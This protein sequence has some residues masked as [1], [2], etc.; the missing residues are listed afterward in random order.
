MGRYWPILNIGWYRYGNPIFLAILAWF[1]GFLGHFWPIFTLFTVVWGPFRAHSGGERP[2][3]G[4][5][6]G[7]EAHLGPIKGVRDPFG[8]HLRGWEA[9]FGPIQGVESLFENKEIIMALSI[10]PYENDRLLSLEIIDRGSET[11]LRSIQRVRGP[12]WAH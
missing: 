1:Y 4:P 11:H 8:A 2:I 3:W 7:S 12:F 5:L 6:K 9:H 10:W